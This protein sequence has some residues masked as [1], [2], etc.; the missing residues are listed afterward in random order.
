VYKGK[1]SAKNDNKVHPKKE[2][3]LPRTTIECEKALKPISEI[4]KSILI[5]SNDTE[6]TIGTGSHIKIRQT[7]GNNGKF[8][9][10]W[11]D[12]NHT[13]KITVRW[14][15]KREV[16]KYYPRAVNLCDTELP[17]F[18]SL[19]EYN[20]NAA[21]TI[22]EKAHEVI[23]AYIGYSEIVQ[24]S[25]ITDIVPEIYI[26]PKKAKSFKYSLHPKYSDFNEFEL[27]FAEELDKTKKLWFRNPPKGCFEIPLLDEGG[28][29]SFNPDFLAWTKGKIFAID[30]KGDHL[31]VSDSHRK[32]LTLKN[33][34][35]GSDL[36][37]KLVTQGQWTADIK[38][39]ND[40]GYTVWYLKNGIV[41][42]NYC[43]N[44]KSCVENCL[45]V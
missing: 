3:R 14:L 11:V 9:Q 28:T 8:T 45:I 10:E 5:F 42:S 22:L 40:D 27:L 19:I 41:T 24:D 2:A 12:T 23:K 36:I 17:K 38:K 34:G 44:L 32:L 25:T 15:F 16:Q 33:R 18:D 37:I 43:R 30:T 20:S 7:I 26:D 6:N 13:N 31:I 35:K 21:G 1:A 4:V 39:I 29:N